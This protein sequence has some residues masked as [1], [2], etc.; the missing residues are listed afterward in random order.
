MKAVLLLKDPRTDND[1][2]A[3]PPCV[4]HALYMG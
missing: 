3:L 2:V 1:V 4:M